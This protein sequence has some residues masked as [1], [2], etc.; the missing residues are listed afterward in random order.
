MPHDYNLPLFFPLKIHHTVL[1]NT[2]RSI[3]KNRKPTFCSTKVHFRLAFE[4]A[5]RDSKLGREAISLFLVSNLGQ[6]QQG[7]LWIADCI[8]LCIGIIGGW[9]CWRLVFAFTIHN[10]LI[11]FRLCNAMC[12]IISDI[13]IMSCSDIIDR[14]HY[15]LVVCQRSASSIW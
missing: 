8:D 12:R 7:C 2:S 13:L 6:Q 10:W 3:F 11:F 14:K 9:I 1:K 5:P 15:T 4:N